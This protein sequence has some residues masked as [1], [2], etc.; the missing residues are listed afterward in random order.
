[1]HPLE[2]KVCDQSPVASRKDN[3]Q[4]A[5]APKELYCLK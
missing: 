4:L 2:T 5:D 1:V 3:R